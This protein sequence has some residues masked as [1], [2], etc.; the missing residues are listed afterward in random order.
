ME[1]M[2][3]TKLNK[4][5]IMAWLASPLSQDKKCYLIFAG[6]KANGQYGEIISD[7]HRQKEFKYQKLPVG[8]MMW[9]MLIGSLLRTLAYN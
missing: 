2:G 5:L 8:S 7:P 4:E 3:P 6:E 9:I 1:M